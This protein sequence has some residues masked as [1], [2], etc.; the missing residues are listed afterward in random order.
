MIA[1]SLT[2]VATVIL[3]LVVWQHRR[4]MPCRCVRGTRGHYATIYTKGRRVTDDL[5]DDGSC[6]DGEV[7]DLDLGTGEE[8]SRSEGGKVMILL[9][10]LTSNGYRRLKTSNGGSS[11]DLTASSSTTGV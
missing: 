1:M 9:K 11:Q 4:R 3:G 7:D 6:A 10:S 5:E 2:A 8:G